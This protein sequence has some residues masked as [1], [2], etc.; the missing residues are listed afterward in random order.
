MLAKL[1]TTAGVFLL[2]GGSALA[3]G[4]GHSEPFLQQAETWVAAA[5]IIFV[6]ALARPV[7]RAMTSSLDKRTDAIK[8][9]LDEAQQFREEAQHT[10][11]E[12]QR[13]QRDAL[14]EAEGIIAEAREEAKRMQ[15][16]SMER[17]E[18]MLER[19]EQQALEMIAAAEAR[20]IADVRAL[21][22]DVAI[23][24]T[25]RILTDVV[26]GQKGDDLVNAAIEEVPAKLN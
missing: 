20:A 15:S 16:A 12:Y 6:L 4:D 8:V 26:E 13:K 10:L 2:T 19:R 24:A 21:T 17:T 23:E 22:A 9:Q 18:Q 14:A 5:F 11:A 3:A 25:R 1:A 7:G